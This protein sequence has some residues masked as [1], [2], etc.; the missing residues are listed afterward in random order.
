MTSLDGITW[1]PRT[2]PN[3]NYTSVCWSAELGIFVAVSNSGT[4]NRVMTSSLKGRPPTSYN[5]FDSSFNNIDQSGNWSLKC[6]ELSSSDSN[7]SIGSTSGNT[8]IKCNAT[9]G[10]GNI[11]LTG[12]TNLLSTAVG[13]PS[14]NYLV[15]TI[16]GVNYKIALL[17]A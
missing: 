8:E 2:T 6:K 14:S 9:G 12:G 5:V 4:D 1:I 16:N 17:N 11:I 15:L 10:G 3:N 13:T 7:V